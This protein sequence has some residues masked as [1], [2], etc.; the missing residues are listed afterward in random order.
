ME[1]LPAKVAR[2]AGAKKSSLGLLAGDGGGQPQGK[3]PTEAIALIT[4]TCPG[5]NETYVDGECVDDYV[6]SESLAEYSDDLVHPGG[7]EGVCFP[8]ARCFGEAQAAVVDL[9]ANPCTLSVRGDP[10]KLNLAIVT[11]DDGECLREDECY[12][13]LDHGT[14]WE[15]VS[16]V[17]VEGRSVVKLH[18]GICKKLAADKELR[19]FEAY[20][21]D[22]RCARNTESQ[23]ECQQSDGLPPSSADA[24]AVVSVA[25]RILEVADP[26]GLDVATTDTATSVQRL[27]VITQTGLRSYSLPS[28]L[29][30]EENIVS[31]DPYAIGSTI[32]GAGTEILITES[33]RFTATSAS[34]P[35]ALNPFAPPL[36]A[37]QKIRGGALRSPFVFLAVGNNVDK[38]GTLLKFNGVTPVSLDPVD[39]ADYTAI[40]IDR[41]LITADS[42]VFGT[43][44]G[45]VGLYNGSSVVQPTPIGPGPVHSLAT[46]SRLA[47]GIF[48]DS[49]VVFRSAEDGPC[50]LPPCAG[51]GKPAGRVE[52]TS[53]GAVHGIAFNPGTSSQQCVYFTD[54]DGKVRYLTVGPGVALSDPVEVGRGTAPAVAI[55]VHKSG[56]YWTVPGPVSKGG[57]IYR[58]KIPD[59]C[60]IAGGG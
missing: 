55:A 13:P 52:P 49:I 5:T 18:K 31:K 56:V 23:P 6:D 11:P 15:V 42:V 50:T 53:A 1:N 46:R 2:D 14:D 36:S 19:I 39:E 40:A 7:D 3:D 29:T 30:N 32:S 57:G 51:A 9:K 48:K 28:P 26:I 33:T 8:T 25:S 47:A 54:N 27:F 44:E 41:D 4:S 43:S 34:T 12:V 24:G 20:S 59:A 21:S 45:K 35:Q 22:P 37:N 38:K 16:G 10:E 60:P 17:K 58:A